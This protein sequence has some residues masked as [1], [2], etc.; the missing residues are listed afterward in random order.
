VQKILFLF[1]SFS[2]T[3]SEV[4]QIHLGGNSSCYNVFDKKIGES[5]LHCA[6]I[7]KFGHEIP[8][9]GIINFDTI[10]IA[11]RHS[12]GISQKKAYCWGDN[13]HHQT[14]VPKGI[15]N[16]THITV[17]K[18]YSCAVQ[19][20][21]KVECWGSGSPLK[22]QESF[23]KVHQIKSG[24]AHI[25]IRYTQKSQ[26]RVTCFGN[27]RYGQLAIPM[28]LTNPIKLDSGGNHSCLIDEMEKGS[29]YVLKCWG[30]SKFSQLN[31]P[32]TM[33]SVIDMALGDRHSCALDLY[34]GLKCWGDNRFEQIKPPTHIDPENI[35]GIKS[36]DRHN[37]LWTSTEIFCW[38]DDFFN[39][40]SV[41][42][43]ISKL[44][45]NTKAKKNTVL[46]RKVEIGEPNK[47]GGTGG[48]FWKV[49]LGGRYLLDK[50]GLLSEIGIIANNKGAD[51]VLGIYNDK[52]GKPHQL[53]AQTK[54]FKL[55][56]GTTVLPIL[57]KRALLD[58]GHY[59]VMAMFSVS[60]EIS[61]SDNGGPGYCYQP[62]TK[63]TDPLPKTLTN[64]KC[65]GAG[66]RFNYFTR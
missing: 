27:N 55:L 18:N 7:K 49:I 47:L 30:Q 38:G 33:E 56:A 26:N 63:F 14:E 11:A 23:E 13:T 66:K 51:A 19:N 65:G 40:N 17:G 29:K 52:G 64:I 32:K 35:L 9:H 5:K 34:Q 4:T 31:A 37:C 28:D 60:S 21:K 54:I 12:C 46:Y 48:V 44:K 8:P 6:G 36:G 25:C 41:P 43:H 39:L 58:P 57:K 15:K 2:L 1:L 22:G 16:V 59:W 20:S 62:V 42:E 45:L 50:K 3:A 61:Q 24:R 10:A 53:M